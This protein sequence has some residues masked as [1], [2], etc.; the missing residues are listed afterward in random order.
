MIKTSLHLKTAATANLLTT[1]LA[2]THLR[3]ELSD[4]TN[5]TYIDSLVAA[6]Q[7]AVQNYTNRRLTAA[8][9]YFYLSAFPT[10]GIVLPFSPVS[11]ITAVTYYDSSNNL[12]TLASGDYF[13]NIYDEPCKIES[14]DTF[15]A[16]Y[17]YR[18]DAVT[19]EFVV[20]YTSPDTCPDALKHA[21]K[22][23]ISDMY[24]GRQNTI[25]ER[26]ELWHM[27]ATPF[28]VFHSTM[29]NT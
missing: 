19:V 16:T 24:S 29:E 3:E 1:A 8:T 12:Q 15:P 2:K 10:T 27:L 11:S 5:D 9:Y 22:L 23:L 13:Y 28:R 25:K 7:D 20:G 4:A 26:F 14:V 6:A 18:A 21:V 17:D